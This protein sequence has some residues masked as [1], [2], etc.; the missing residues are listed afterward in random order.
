MPHA[1]P[2]ALDRGIVIH[3]ALHRL[4]LDDNREPRNP[5]TIAQVDIESAVSGALN[6]SYR[7]FPEQ[8]R[9]RE[10]G[11]L[12]T[13]LEAWLQLDLARGPVQIVGLEV[14]QEIVLQGIR[15]HLRLD[16]IDRVDEARAAGSLVVIDYKS[17]A[18][19]T[20]F[21][22]NSEAGRLIDPQLPIYACSNQ[23]IRGVLYAQV[24]ATN[25]RLT[26]VADPQL[27]L[28]PVRLQAPLDG[29]WDQQLGRWR[30]QL[31]GLANEIKNGY[32]A[33]SPVGPQI[34]RNCHLQDFCRLSS[35]ADGLPTPLAPVAAS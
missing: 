35:L 25:L 7:R 31:D 16:R 22:D 32:A 11:R 26:G 4:Y 13:L 27:T 1:F 6:K 18:V 21:V 8:F 15:L 17:G 29:D 2:D 30:Q 20:R 24:N 19:S 33:V 34:C 23:L 12:T 5:E 14:E 28:G 9:S 3:D 10:R